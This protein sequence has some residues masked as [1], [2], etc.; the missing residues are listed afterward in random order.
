MA[1]SIC[2]GCTRTVVS[3]TDSSFHHLFAHIARYFMLLA[4]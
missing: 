3:Y 2:D 1:Q 4:V